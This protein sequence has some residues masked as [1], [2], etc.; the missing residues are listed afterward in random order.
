MY[1]KRSKI[2]TPKLVRTVV[3]AFPISTKGYHGPAHWFRVR[4]NGLRVAQSSGADTHVVEL[5]ALF[6]DSQRRNEGWD[7]KHGR[8]GAALAALLRGTLFDLD[9]E[10]FE[11][12]HQACC[13]HTSGRHGDTDDVTVM[14]CWD[15]DRL[16]LGRVGIRPDPQRLFTAAARSEELRGWAYE[17]SL[18]DW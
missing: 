17:R 13:G 10:R 9:D 1:P 6:H 15:A 7:P 18:R 2:L 3:D 14:T 8:R 5:F 12:L 11:L 16:D 4:A